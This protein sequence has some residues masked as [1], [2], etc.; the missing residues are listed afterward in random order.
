MSGEKLLL[1]VDEVH[2]LSGSLVHTAA[3]HVDLLPGQAAEVVEEDGPGLLPHM[4]TYIHIYST[5]TVYIAYVN[6][7][8]EQ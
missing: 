5:Y 3:A 4:H 2:L 6:E 8:L 7:V 1:Q